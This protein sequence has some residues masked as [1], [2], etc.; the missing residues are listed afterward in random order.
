MTLTRPWRF[1]LAIGL[2]LAA[3]P[4]L[5]AG[6]DFLDFRETPVLP[7]VRA[8]LE[9]IG[10]IFEE[11]HGGVRKPREWPLEKAQ[12]RAFLE[13]YDLKANPIDETLRVSLLLRGLRMDQDAGRIL[14]GEPVRP[15][16]NLEIQAFKKTMEDSQRANSLERLTQ[17][18]S[19]QNPDRPLHFNH[20]IKAKGLGAEGPPDLVGALQNPNQKAGD[21]LSAARGA[22]LEGAR[23]FDGKKS[24]PDWDKDTQPVKPDWGGA[25]RA[26]YAGDVERRLGSLLSAS[27]QAHLAKNP[28]GRELLDRFRGKN[29]K[30]ELPAFLIL[31]INDSMDAAYSAPNK[32]LIFNQTYIVRGMTEKL[33]ESKRTELRQELADPKKFAEYLLAHPEA[34]DAFIAG[35]DVQMVHELTHGFQDRL[36]TLSEEQERGN[37][38]PGTIIEKETEAFF[39]HAKYLHYKLVHDPESV[40]DNP[41]LEEYGSFLADAGGFKDG[42]KDAYTENYPTGA[43]TFPTLKSIQRERISQTRLLMGEKAYEKIGELKLRGLEAG[44]KELEAEE[45]RVSARMLKFMTEEYPAI[46]IEGRRRLAALLIVKARLEPEWYKRNGYLDS[47]QKLV[48]DEKSL[49]LIQ[50]LRKE[51]PE[52]E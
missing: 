43:A 9:K 52:D 11:T 39:A 45:S 10:Y 24:L 20:W 18:L 21:L 3:A 48:S 42:V 8:D 32:A 34:R 44:M 19:E 35:H 51:P 29:G 36:G 14:V 31:P 47:A 23:V 2:F 6:T 46:K 25:S 28:A 15:A 49:R 17:F 5:Q 27:A 16:T 4:L 38:P 1:T 13:P 26:P 37:L 7:E 30:V 12:F 22:Q 33:P 41:R 40:R 50:S